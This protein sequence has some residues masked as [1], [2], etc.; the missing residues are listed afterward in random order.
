MAIFDR[1]FRLTA[2]DYLRVSFTKG[3]AP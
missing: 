3:V 1:Q 2:L